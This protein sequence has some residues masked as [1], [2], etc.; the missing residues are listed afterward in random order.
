[1]CC[2]ELVNTTFAAAAFVDIGPRSREEFG[3]TI[4]DRCMSIAF[5]AGFSKLRL[6]HVREI[7]V[8]I[9]RLLVGLSP[10]SVDRIGSYISLFRVLGKC[11]RAL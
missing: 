6:F 11:K 1:M 7:L 9:M 10:D 4:H 2:V 5:S 8:Y 3:Q